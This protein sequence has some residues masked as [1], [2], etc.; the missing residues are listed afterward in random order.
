[1]DAHE[2]LP[3]ATARR[4]GPNG[5]LFHATF[6][7]AGATG[8]PER[9]LPLQLRDAEAIGSFEGMPPVG[10][11]RRRVAR[12]GRYDCRRARR[13]RGGV[14]G[15]R[16]RRSRRAAARP[17]GRPRL[18]RRPPS[19]TAPPRRR[20]SSAGSAPTTRATPPTCAARAPRRRSA[21]RCP[22]ERR[23]RRLRRGGGRAHDGG[24]RRPAARRAGER[25]PLPALLLRLPDGRRLDG[26]AADP[27][28]GRR[29]APAQPAAAAWCSRGRRRE[30]TCE[31]PSAPIVT[32]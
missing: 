21:R 4:L 18:P 20:S 24:R 1:M 26:L 2:S 25:E 32:P 3:A 6:H 9:L 13:L 12:V 10:S 29:A 16:R 14:A 8:A 17:P 23:A 22:G 15:A 27:L 11:T 28:S 30:T 19:P 7:P 31:T 5:V